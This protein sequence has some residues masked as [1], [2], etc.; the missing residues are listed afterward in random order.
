MSVDISVVE[1]R[2]SRLV[3]SDDGSSSVRRALGFDFCPFRASQSP[4]S[5]SQAAGDQ[6]TFAEL[7]G[8]HKDFSREDYLPGEDSA[9]PFHWMATR[10]VTRSRRP[11]S[12][13]KPL[14]GVPTRSTG[15]PT[16][17]SVI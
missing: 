16:Q 10:R 3:S 6:L 12:W 1:K 11:Q 9:K 15:T 5:I 7:H 8:L 17:P 4:A 14:T 2:I 13:I